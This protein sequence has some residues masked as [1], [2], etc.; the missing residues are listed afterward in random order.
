MQESTLSQSQRL[1]VL[2]AAFLGWLSA[3]V[4]M[5]LGPLAARPA[6]IALVYP[7]SMAA[8]AE[9]P[10]GGEAIVGA[11]FARWLSAFLLGGAFGGFGFGYLGDRIGRTRAMGLSILCF[12]LLTGASGL[13]EDPWQ[14]L[15]L[16]FLAGLGIG[17]MWPT[18][19]SL[20]SEAWPSASRPTVAGLMGA[21]A[22]LGIL[23]MALVGQWIQVTPESWR[24]AMFVGAVPAVIGLAA[25]AVVPESPAW[26]AQ[27]PS[28]KSASSVVR[29]DEVFRP[30][31][32]RRT[33]IGI[34]VGTIPLLGTWASSKWLVPWADK[35]GES[36]AIAQGVW[37]LGATLGSAGGAWVANLFGRRSTYFVIS[38]ATLIINLAIYTWLDPAKPMFLPTVFALGLVAT[39]FFGWLPLYLPE[40]FPTRVRATG[41]GVAFNF[42]RFVTAAGVLAA[43]QLMSM[44]HGDYA[45]VGR[46]TAWVYALGM[47]V[48][49]F[50]PDTRDTELK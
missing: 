9:L 43:G 36:S 8:G 39:V 40:L 11:W 35:A 20:A 1:V 19:V 38:L 27:S 3:G 46:V 29:M 41:T 12:S 23:L 44:F 50:A 48:I 4:E 22:N 47:I 10:E 26:L 33:L 24:W 42:G 25:L 30:P 2:A 17:G 16:R 31:Y 7:S 45:Q 15:A 49:L 14:M 28:A 18:G 6:A 21:A 34:A 5:G 32:L 13:V 37:A